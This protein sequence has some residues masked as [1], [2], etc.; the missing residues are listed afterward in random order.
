[1]FENLSDRE[2]KLLLA[3]GALVPIVIIFFVVIRTNE[4]FKRYAQEQE[5]LNSQIDEQEKLKIERKKAEI[6]QEY[7][8]NASLPSAVD[9]AESTVILL[10]LKNTMKESGLSLGGNEPFLRAQGFDR[11][12]NSLAKASSL[13]LP[14]AAHWLNSMT[15]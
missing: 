12:M 3:I 1:M 10:W 13:R 6:R 11:P 9:R 2:K 14:P 8:A 5:T 7:Y 4:A 15:F